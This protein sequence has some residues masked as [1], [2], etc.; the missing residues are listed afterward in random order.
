MMNFFQSGL[1]TGMGSSGGINL[2]TYFDLLNLQSNNA[3][4]FTQVSN[5]ISQWNDLSGNNNHAVQTTA[6][7]RPLYNSGSPLWD[8]SNDTMSLTS[9]IARSTYSLYVVFRKTAV[10]STSS[11]LF[12]AG[13][14]AGSNANN[15]LR[16]D[17]NSTSVARQVTMNA[18]DRP[19]T[20]NFTAVWRLGGEEQY[21]VLS[22]RR[23]NGTITV[24]MNDR[25]CIRNSISA[26]P[27]WLTY[28][29]N[30]G[31]A[32]SGSNMGG[33]ILAFCMSSSVFDD[34]TDALIRNAF[35]NRYGVLSTSQQKI[36][37][38]GDSITQG[39]SVANSFPSYI[40]PLATSLG[41]PY[42]NLGIAGE[43][44]SDGLVRYQSQAFSRPYTDKVYIMFG[45]NDINASV[46]AATCATQLETMAQGFITAGYPVRNICLSSPCYQKLGANS[47]TLDGYASAIIAKANGLGVRYA[48]ILTAIRNDASPDALMGDNL[49]P[50]SSGNALI[51]STIATA[52][53]G[54]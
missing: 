18:V 25:T 6:I 33:N 51:A 26:N 15:F 17:G 29:S 21:N 37:C 40:D 31:S 42:V 10:N 1:Y 38:I 2:D 32:F 12:G 27:T 20:A 5:A 13:N 11:A 44:A 35:Y 3:S 4:N 22:F 47:S 14:G 28:I 30:I 9:E 24:K 50:N 19:A 54:A 7:N 53:S 36:V 45:A 16:F 43:K 52:F 49:H 23:T 34:T 46:S 41:L 39:G 8:G 48:D